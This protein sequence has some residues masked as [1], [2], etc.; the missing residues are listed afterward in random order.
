MSL[1]R[2]HWIFESIFFLSS[3]PLGISSYK[4]LRTHSN[5]IIDFSLALV[6]CR[7]FSYFCN[8][9]HI[10]LDC[11]AIFWLISTYL[12]TKFSKTDDLPADWPPTTAIWGKSICIWTP[13]LVNASW[14]LLMMGIRLSIPTLPDILVEI[15]FA[16]KFRAKLI[17]FQFFPSEKL[18][19]IRKNQ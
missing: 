19:S 2:R 14:S 13:K 4:F 11:I 17:K 12:P 7:K 5:I 10:S 8:F 15:G 1:I 16:H 6:D 9:P 18:F 3:T